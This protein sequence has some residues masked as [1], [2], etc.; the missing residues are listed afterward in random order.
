MI[1]CDDTLQVRVLIKTELGLEDD[2]IVVG[3]AANGVEAIDL[4]RSEQP[5]VV[6]LDLGMPVMDGLE[7]LPGIR[8]AAPTARVIV[9]S[10]FDVSEMAEKAVAAGASRYIEKSAPAHQLVAA[11][12]KTD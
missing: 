9:Y 1:V 8:Q 12:R 2:M 7:A 10:S 11:V 3:E 5:D 4:A 6:L